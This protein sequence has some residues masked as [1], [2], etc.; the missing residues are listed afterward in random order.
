MSIREQYERAYRLAREIRGLQRLIHNSEVWNG[1]YDMHT[2]AYRSFYATKISQVTD[3]GIPTEIFAAASRSYSDHE[4]LWPQH[5]AHTNCLGSL[6]LDSR[7]D[8]RRDR[9]AANGHILSKMYTQNKY[10]VW[11]PNRIGSAVRSA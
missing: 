7:N 3:S 6:L 2:R 4:R 11:N 10:M 5:E 1:Y 9:K 8:T